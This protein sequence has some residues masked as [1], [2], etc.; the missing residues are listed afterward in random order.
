MT[1]AST[2]QTALDLPPWHALAAA[3]V[4]RQLATSADK[5]LD[6]GE[7]SNR[8]ATHGPNRL[9]EGKRR[10]PVT[11]FLT[12]LKDNYAAHKHPAVHDWLATNPRIAVHFTPT[13]ASWMNLVE[14]WF[15]IIERQAIHRGTFRSVRDLT[16]KIRA[17]INGWNDRC[18]P[19]TWTKTADYILAKADR[20]TTSETRH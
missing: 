17:F 11:R 8:L 19:F 3:D 6:A 15:G 20:R 14:V 1:A 9:P 4:V 18:H 2:P 5:G 13:H 10:G 7:L 16:T 12:Q